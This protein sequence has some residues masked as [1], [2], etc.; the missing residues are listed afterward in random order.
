MDISI[1]TKKLLEDLGLEYQETILDRRGTLALRVTHKGN[2][3]VLKSISED[4]SEE[5]SH[6]AKLLLREAEILAKIPELT[7]NLYLSH[8]TNN[9][10]HWLLMREV[11]GQE[12]NKLAKQIRKND[13]SVEEQNTELLS[14]ILKVSGFYDKLYQGGYL[15]G[16]I[17]P[18]HTYLEQNKITVID[19]GLSRKVSEINPLYKG[20]FIYFVAPEVASCMLTGDTSIDY[21]PRSEVYA[22]GTTLY[23]FFAGSLSLDFGIPLKELKESPMDKKL[24]AVIKNKIFSFADAGANPY[25]ELEEILAKSLSTDPKDRFE[26]SSAL[27][28]RLL[29]LENN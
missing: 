18:A 24:L 4:G 11:E 15:H 3:A 8:G 12:V 2:P 16:D 14:L 29:E 23:R 1:E 27:H 13:L 6:K 22:L 9:E 17:Q 20:G 7:N 21:T 28:R 19:W 25:H 10:R 5:S 26:N